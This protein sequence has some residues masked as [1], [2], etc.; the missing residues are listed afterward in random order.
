[1]GNVDARCHYEHGYFVVQTAKPFYYPGEHITGSIYI[2]A[3]THIETKYI[4]LEIKGKEKVSF[5]QTETRDGQQ[6]HE[7]R[8]AKKEII[9]YS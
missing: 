8:K 9:H 7:K 5:M 6:H 4:E 1:M 2:R 3:N